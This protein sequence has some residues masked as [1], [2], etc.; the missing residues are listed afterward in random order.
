[1]KSCIFSLIKC[2]GYHKYYFYVYTLQKI[3]LYSRKTDVH[4]SFDSTE[5]I[6]ELSS[7]LEE[8]QMST[9]NRHLFSFILSLPLMWLITRTHQLPLKVGW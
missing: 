2:L 1:M 9:S 5:N 7:V 6:P 8:N 4:Q 3:F